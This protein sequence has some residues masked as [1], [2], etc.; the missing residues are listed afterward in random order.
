MTV[1]FDVDDTV[2]SRTNAFVEACAR[3]FRPPLEDPFTVF[4]CCNRRGDEV[5]KASQTGEITM[6]EMV[7]YRYCRGFA[8]CSLTL[9]PEDAL[10][11]QRTYEQ[12]LT[13][14]TCSE[15]MLSIL[16]LCAARADKVGLLTNG[17]SWK[18]RGK[19]RAL[20]IEPLFSPDM[21]IISG[22]VGCD[23]PEPEIFRL[24]ENRAGCA[25]R[26][27]LYVGDAP[28]IDILPAAAAGWR[29]V[30][31]N[32]RKMDHPLCAATADY[33]A[34]TEEELLALLPAA[35]SEA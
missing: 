15:T 8:D 13:H 16:R 11:L 24:A 20:G 9:S 19:I 35:L 6:D 5:F 23:K 17:P 29:T 34:D 26:Q 22:E 25:G 14:I 2:Y 18:Q 4:S 3:F 31:F 30:W 7:I 21:I 33:I 28:E 27:I 10:A 1:F 32:R 12:V